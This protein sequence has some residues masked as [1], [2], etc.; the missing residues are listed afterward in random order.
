MSSSALAGLVLIVYLILFRDSMGLI[1]FALPPIFYGVTYWVYYFLMEK[2]IDQKIKLIYRTIHHEK[3]GRPLSSMKIDMGRDVFREVN[4]DV[5]H[6]A[7]DSRKE[8]E[9]LKDQAQYRREF[10]G[11]LSH[12]LKTPLTIIQGNILTLLEGAVEDKAFRE[13]FLL[14]AAENV[15]R[16]EALTNDLDHITKLESGKD[17]LNLERFDLVNLVYKV[18]DNLE[19][20]AKEHGIDIKIDTKKNTELWVYADK[21]KIYQVVTNLIVNSIKY[22]KKKGETSIS[23]EDLGDNVMIEISDDG[24]GIGA[25]HIPRLFERFYRVDKSRARHA[26]GSGLGL[27]IVKHIIDGHNQS[28]TVRSTEGKGS[29]FSFTLK[30]DK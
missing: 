1:L 8:I 20:K 9:T 11:N 3:I 29:T 13:K 18:A 28:I 4:R 10:I 15:E 26:G 5:E 7:E 24:I 25:K 6:W 30:K 21:E 27:A 12:E 17:I 23:F 16:L 19:D 14:K 2:F 22:G